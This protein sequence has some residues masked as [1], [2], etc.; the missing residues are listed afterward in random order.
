MIYSIK[1]EHGIKLDHY[2]SRVV[3]LQAVLVSFLES[4]NHSCDMHT[5]FRYKV[6][7]P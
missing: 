3:C 7:T 5:Q 1:I 2:Y 6:V 4:K